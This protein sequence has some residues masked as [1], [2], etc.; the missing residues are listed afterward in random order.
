MPDRDQDQFPEPGFEPPA[1]SDE[2]ERPSPVGE[3][4]SGSEATDDES[5]NGYSRVFRQTS[6]TLE[7][8][9]TGMAA[10]FGTLLSM[11]YVFLLCLLSAERVFGDPRGPLLLTAVLVVTVESPFL[12]RLWSCAWRPVDPIGP[13]IARRSPPFQFPFRLI[14]ILWWL[15]HVIVGLGGVI[16]F[17]MRALQQ[18]FNN[19]GF[20]TVI[21]GLMMFGMSVCC[22]V[23][24]AMLIK[25]LTGSNGMVD[26]F[27]KYRLVVDALIT[28]TAIS[29][30]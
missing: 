15:L 25:Q 19:P 1:R 3:S 29:L 30:A 13:A 4:P 21:S 2:V 9:E 26:W 27:W 7:R 16:T 23:F 14:V 12:Y 28:V 6:T 10:F 22:N 20:L 5:S 17:E 24:I 8:V 11:M 18:G